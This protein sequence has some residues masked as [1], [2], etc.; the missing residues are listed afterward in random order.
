MQDIMNS[1]MLPNCDIKFGLDF[2]NSHEFLAGKDEYLRC[3]FQDGRGD[4]FVCGCYLNNK[5]EFLEKINN[6]IGFDIARHHAGIFYYYILEEIVKY[7]VDL[8]YLECMY[9]KFN[10][11]TNSRDV[12]IERMTANITTYH[13][14]KNNVEEIIQ[15]L[16]MM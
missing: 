4:C 13:T 10:I 3:N 15:W 16:K 5:K 7:D 11:D 8:V 2:L 1:M 14:F 9:K 12:L 6:F